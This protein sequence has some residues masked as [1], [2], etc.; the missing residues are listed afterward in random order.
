MTTKYKLY[1][2]KENGKKERKSTGLLQIHWSINAI[3]ILGCCHFFIA[4]KREK[5]KNIIF[6]KMDDFLCTQF[7]IQ[8]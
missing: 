8:L 4:D 5:S 6:Y 3:L 2:L 1:S 7:K